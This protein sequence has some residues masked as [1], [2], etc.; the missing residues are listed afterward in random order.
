MVTN[1]TVSKLQDMHLGTMARRFKEQLDDPRIP[2]QISALRLCCGDKM[3]SSAAAGSEFV[4]NCPLSMN[5]TAVPCA[6]NRTVPGENRK[7]FSIPYLPL[8]FTVL[9]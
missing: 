3:K 7:N 5:C 2:P 9:K 6:G 8:R 4:R 1:E